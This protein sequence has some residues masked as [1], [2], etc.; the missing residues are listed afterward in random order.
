MGRVKEHFWFLLVQD[1]TL[2]K[3]RRICAKIFLQAM[4]DFDTRTPV[5]NRWLVN[6]TRLWNAID[7]LEEPEHC[8]ELMRQQLPEAFNNPADSNSIMFSYH[9]EN[10]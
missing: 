8:W 2:T 1:E 10:Q 6:A 4:E 7:S 5:T 3:V 9:G